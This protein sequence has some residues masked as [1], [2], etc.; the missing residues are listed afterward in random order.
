VD[1]VLYNKCTATD[2]HHSVLRPSVVITKVSQYQKGKTKLDFTEAR[3][4]DWHWH[5]LG[6]KC[7]SASH[8]RQITTPASHHS[9]FLQARC[10]SCHRTNSV[11][12][13]QID[14]METEQKKQVGLSAAADEPDDN[15]SAAPGL[16]EE[17]VTDPEIK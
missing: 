7:K 10:P 13:Q 6:H 9:D 16:P 12:A 11:K 15:V 8:P 14:V 1:D 3:D 5:Q 2:T 17:C 4:S